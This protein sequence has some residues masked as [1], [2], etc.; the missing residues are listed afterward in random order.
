[1]PAGPNREKCTDRLMA[2]ALFAVPSLRWDGDTRWTP[3][4]ATIATIP[5]I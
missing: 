1:M 5:G 3:L 2:R 4:R